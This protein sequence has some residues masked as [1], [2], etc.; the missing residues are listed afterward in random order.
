MKKLL[1]ILACCFLFIIQ[2]TSQTSFLPIRTIE[3][4]EDGILVTY[5]FND[6]IIYPNHFYPGSS[7]WRYQGFGINETPGEPAIPF[8]TDMFV[9]PQGYTADINLTEAIY[10]DTLFVMSP[11]IP[12]VDE[13]SLIDSVPDIVPYYGLFPLHVIE[14]DS[15]QFYRG[16]TLQQVTI[17]PVQYDHTNQ[18][19]RAYSQIKYKITF[20]EDSTINGVRK[21]NRH[22]EK[23]DRFLSNIA[24]SCNSKNG[25]NYY[26]R[27]DTSNNYC[28]LDTTSYLIV[29]TDKYLSTIQ[30]FVEWKKMKGFQVFVESRINGIWTKESV[31]ETIESYYQNHFIKYILIV[32][33]I[34][35]VPAYPL[36]MKS[37]VTDYNYGIP[38]GNSIIPNVFRGRIPVRTIGELDIVLNKI[39]QY[40]RTPINDNSF[41]QTGVNCAFFQDWAPPHDY[42]NRCFTMTSENIR[43]HLVTNC[44]KI[45]NRVYTTPPGAHPKY[46]NKDSY[47]DGAA[48]P[49][50]LKEENFAWDG[51]GDSILHYINEGAFYVFH[52][53]HGDTIQWG[54][55]SFMIEHIDSLNNGRKLPVV[56]SIDCQTGMYNVS[57]RECFAE[58]FL[59]KENGGCVAIFAATQDSYSGY[60]DALSLG[61]FDAIWPNLVPIHRFIGYD[62]YSMVEQPIYE[63]GQIMD[64]GL[65]RMGETYGYNSL[66]RETWKL[67]HCFGDPTMQIWTDTPQNFVEPLVF[68]RNDSIFVHVEDGDC[69]I[70]FYNKVT[71]NVVSYKGNYAGYANPSDSLVIC[72]DRHNYIPYIWDYSKDVYIQNE[73]IEGE[74]RF[75]KGN[76]IHIGNHVTNTKDT[77][78][79]NIQ[80]S[81]ITIIGKQLDLQPGTYIESDFEF[82]N[83]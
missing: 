1:T 58:H 16:T 31:K 47:S 49:E 70:T 56:F 38:S 24:I 51:N 34:E 52:R 12:V 35:D 61:M 82:V 37:G 40:E 54:E 7:F 64:Q 25:K 67:F 36:T 22:R 26:N 23:E 77:G 29:T 45:V 42:E 79:V 55:P 33:G 65:V 63:L 5:K 57:Q 53:D 69:K 6:A 81:T 13:Y 17:K 72:L 46:W 4:L 75:Y 3:N 21:K 2:L 62:S 27:Q 50:E 48:I 19:L 73:N 9:I 30:K 41:Y 28:S 71:G 78:D 66:K 44:G 20:V 14:K 8:R 10:K 11:S 15:L 32:G 83:Q 80:N 74:V 43:N 76:T 59:K 39:I 18:T 60:N 68:L